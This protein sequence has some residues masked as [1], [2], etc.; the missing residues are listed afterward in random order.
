M[1]ER[2]LAVVETVESAKKIDGCGGEVHHEVG[3]RLGDCDDF[4][5]FER[6]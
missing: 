6:T 3:D 1:E 4:V 5:G 2:F